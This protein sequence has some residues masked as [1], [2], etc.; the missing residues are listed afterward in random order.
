MVQSGSSAVDIDRAPS[1]ARSTATTAGTELLTASTTTRTD[2]RRA[3]AITLSAAVSVSPSSSRSAISLASVPVSNRPSCLAAAGSIDM[4]EE[5]DVAARQVDQEPPVEEPVGSFAGSFRG[6][7]AAVAG[8]AVQEVLRV[9][10]GPHRADW[11]RGTPC[12]AF[13]RGGHDPLEPGRF[14]GLDESAEGAVAV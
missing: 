13:Q 4:S 3:P 9:L 12:S 10:R 14:A 8:R 5:P 7:D 6:H 2:V 1:T 11:V